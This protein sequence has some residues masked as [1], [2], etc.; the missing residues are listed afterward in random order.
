VADH[1][2]D[3][4]TLERWLRNKTA[5]HFRIWRSA[6]D[7]FMAVAVAQETICGVGAIRQNGALELCY[8]H[9]AWQR[10]GIGA[11]ASARTGG[12][13]PGVGAFRRCGSLALGPR[14]LSMSATAYGFLPEESGPG[15][16]VLYDYHYA[17]TLQ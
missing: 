14:E 9:P 8:V 2:D 1:Q 15:Y 3:A 16:G 12:P 7:S 10:C 6:P 4:P 11:L 13:G 17:K 5:E